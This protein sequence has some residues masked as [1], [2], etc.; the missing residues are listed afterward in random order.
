M[1][2]HL[3]AAVAASLLSMTACAAQTTP[4]PAQPAPTAAPMAMPPQGPPPGARLPNEV[5]WFR[6]SAEMRALFLQSYRLA[7][8]QIRQAAAGQAAGN[9]AVILDAD[10]TVL[11]NS[12]YQ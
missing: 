2:K 10:E 8:D 5:H 1:R 6:N 12:L 3:S 7:G 9:W 11:D 4:P